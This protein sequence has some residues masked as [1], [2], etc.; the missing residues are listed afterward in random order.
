MKRTIF[1]TILVFSLCKG[2]SQ[3]ST[4][5]G[6]E[7]AA[8]SIKDMNLPIGKTF[9]IPAAP[10]SSGFMN[11]FYFTDA[12]GVL[13]KIEQ[14]LK[15]KGKYQVN[16]FYFQNHELIKIEASSSKENFSNQYRSYYYSK[17]APYSEEGTVDTEHIALKQMASRLGEIYMFAK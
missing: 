9:K 1:L 8:A 14:E 2:Y 4:I 5:A 6:I 16:H 10:D 15:D 11:V 3:N 7:Q 12:K 13:Y 17:G